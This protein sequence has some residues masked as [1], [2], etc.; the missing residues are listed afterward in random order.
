M[1]RPSAEPIRKARRQPSSG[2]MTRRVEQHDRACR[3]QRAADPER[4]IDREVGAAAIARRDHLLNGRIDG[5]IF[6]ADPRPRQ[7]PEQ[8]ETGEI[9]AESRRRRRDEIK[10]ERDEEQ[11][12]AAEPVGHPAE[13]KR[14]GDRADEVEA[15]GEADVGIGKMQARAG[16]ERAGN[17]AGERHFKPVEHPGHAEREDDQR[18]K[19][20]PAQPVEP[21]R[22]AGLD[23]A[24]IFE[25]C[26]SPIKG[27]LTIRALACCRC[28]LF[29]GDPAGE[30]G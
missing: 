26:L 1:T 7:Q 29:A 27:S 20:A 4:A 14:A 19:P 5:A 9:P 11:E 3:A 23:R 2:L 15:R 10:P 21:R 18:M 24:A 30:T 8:A 17:G 22:D 28:G 16:F 13:N 6:A 25:S 12:T